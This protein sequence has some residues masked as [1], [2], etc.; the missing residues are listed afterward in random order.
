MKLYIR[1]KVFSFRDKFTVKDEYG[2]DHYFVEGDL[3]SF[4]KHLHI[5]DA[6][7]REVIRIR[8]KVWSFLHRFYVYVEDKLVAEVV[9]E[10]TFFKPRYRIEGPGWEVSGDWWEH[11]YEITSGGKQ[12][13]S[14]QKEWM[15]WGDSYQVD[16]ADAQDERMA[17]AVV[18]AIDC[19]VACAENANT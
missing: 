2:N 13:V 3:F 18:L 9:K 7:G 6:Y 14:V 1:Q 19:A 12:I 17:L 5:R 16:I 15:T 4:G 11:T 10:F 8:Q